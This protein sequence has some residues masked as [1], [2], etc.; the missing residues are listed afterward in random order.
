[1]RDYINIKYDFEEN[2][3]VTIENEDKKRRKLYNYKTLTRMKETNWQ[4]L[5]AYANTHYLKEKSCMV[6]FFL[7]CFVA[8]LF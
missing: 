7:S 8:L 2:Y 6:L 4:I 5:Y 1:M 3:E